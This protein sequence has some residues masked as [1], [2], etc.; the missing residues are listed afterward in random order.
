[1]RKFKRPYNQKLYDKEKKK[2]LE[3]LDPRIVKYE[4]KE[5]FHANEMKFYEGGTFETILSEAEISL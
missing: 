1:M 2:K 5:F 3:Y 4:E